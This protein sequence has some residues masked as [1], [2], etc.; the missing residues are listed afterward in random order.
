MTTWM[1][2]ATRAL[3][4]FRSFSFAASVAHSLRHFMMRWDTHCIY[5]GDEEEIK[6]KM[7]WKHF[8]DKTEKICFESTRAGLEIWVIWEIK[9]LKRGYVLVRSN[10]SCSVCDECGT[11]KPPQDTK[12]N[13]SKSIVCEHTQSPYVFCF[14]SCYELLLYIYSLAARYST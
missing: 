2:E 9:S 14:P 6:K 8:H 4:L 3:Q 5:R 13:P 11:S 12:N 7:K 10:M 1:N